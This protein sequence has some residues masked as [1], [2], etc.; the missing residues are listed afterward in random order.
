[1]GLAGTPVACGLAALLIWRVW[2]AWP[3]DLFWLVP[4]ALGGVLL[5]ALAAERDVRRLEFDRAGG[6]GGLGAAIRRLLQADLLGQSD[7]SR[8]SPWDRVRER[9]NRPRRGPWD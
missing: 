5:Y 2:V 3:G 7:P 4:G 9:L 6:R 8:P 1:M